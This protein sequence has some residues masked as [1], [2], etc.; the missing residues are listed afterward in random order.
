MSGREL[1]Y[2]A[3]IEKTWTD[4]S[5]RRL[6][7]AFRAYDRFIETLSP[8]VREH[9][10][11]G[12][13]QG[14]AYVVVFGKTQVGKTTLI[15]DLMGLSGCSL[16]R[17]SNVLRG[18]REVGKSA[19]ATAM[20][21]RRSSDD[22]WQF[23]HGTATASS[24]PMRYDDAGMTA[25]LG[26]VREQMSKK[27]L[28]ADKPFI[29]WI[30]NDCFDGD[31]NA[32]FSVRMLDLPGDHAADA[33]E[34]NHVQQMAQ[35][36]VPN[37]DL[38][39]LVGKGDDLSFLKPA[40][41]ELPSIEDWQIVPN[42]FRIVTTYS[43][44]AQSVR[45]AIKQ[46]KTVDAEFF[47]RHLLEQIRTFKELKLHEDAADTQRFFPLEFGDSWVNA[48]Q[49]LVTKLKP[50]IS[51]LR[52]QLHK[53]INASATPN[54]R[55]RNAVDVHVTVVKIKEAR[56]QQM[57][58]RLKGVKKQRGEVLKECVIAETGFQDTQTL[59]DSAQKFLD[60]LPYEELKAQVKNGVSFNIVALLKAVD[61]LGTNTSKFNALINEFTSE[62]KTQFLSAQPTRVTKEE[63]RFWAAVQPRLEHH[64]DKVE[65]LVEAEFASLRSKFSGYSLKEYYP[66]FSDDF[67]NDKHSMRIH[68]QKS[69]DSVGVWSAKLWQ[70]WAK[71]RLQQLADDVETSSEDQ[72]ALQRVL[73]ERQKA[74]KLLDSEIDRAEEERNI[75]VKKMET[76]E[77]SSRKFVALLEQAYLDELRERRHRIAQAPTATN[78]FMELLA[79][80]Q[81]IN[82]RSK[83]TST[84]YD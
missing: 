56:L 6:A 75:F 39:L 74:L 7:W 27:R 61:G 4:L 16:K 58:E 64:V 40:S 15:L 48:K 59:T 53:D 82:E 66:K 5:Q 36:Y 54:A 52:H 24:E 79:T 37:A 26:D 73:K 13:E 50:V 55:L 28:Q 32:G 34:R 9:F 33:V 51:A 23:V 42:R 29:V 41:L 17:V 35:K 20:E 2:P 80:D 78:A 44:T 3:S 60:A 38:I 10:P 68:M 14:E 43:F 11:K 21:Y 69:A 77:A 63:R 47:R 72:K 62:L 30:P 22:H 12:D 49:D 18:G 25:A 57:G 19:T 45:D 67:S 83:L 76:E 8:D 70:G 71:K 84:L 81:L 65:A 1:P 46:Q 31:K